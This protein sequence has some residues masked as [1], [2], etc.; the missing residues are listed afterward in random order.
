MPILLLILLRTAACWKANI[1]ILSLTSKK[2]VWVYGMHFCHCS[3]ALVSQKFRPQQQTHSTKLLKKS[4]LPM[5]FFFPPF[6]KYLFVQIKWDKIVFQS[7][8]FQDTFDTIRIC[9]KPGISSSLSHCSMWRKTSR[10]VL[11][12][13]CLEMF[14]R[15]ICLSYAMCKKKNK[16]AYAT[17]SYAVM[18]TSQS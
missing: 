1:E 8:L 7:K 5:I 2:H 18:S 15:W 3:S 6:C 9:N 12:Q 14:L 16:I 11:L 10:Y 4:Q 13:T 17:E